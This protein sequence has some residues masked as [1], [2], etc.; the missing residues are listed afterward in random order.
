[1]MWVSKVDFKMI[2]DCS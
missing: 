1:M 2:F